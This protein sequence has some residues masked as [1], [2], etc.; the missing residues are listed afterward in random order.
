M[1]WISIKD[2]LPK[3][4]TI[5][6]VN[7]KDSVMVAVLRQDK[8]EKPWWYDV[9]DYYDSLHTGEITH[10]INFPNLPKNKEL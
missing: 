8:N 9:M 10:W 3:V 7:Q 2:R 6:L 4:G 5:V 1:K